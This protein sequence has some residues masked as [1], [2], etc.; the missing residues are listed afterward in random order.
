ME[1]NS[2]AESYDYSQEEISYELPIN[3]PQPLRTTDSSTERTIITISIP[4]VLLAGAIVALTVDGCYVLAIVPITLTACFVVPPIVLCLFG[5]RDVFD[6][7]LGVCYIGLNAIVLAPLILL[8]S[9]YHS[10]GGPLID[11]ESLTNYV[12][13]SALPI[14]PLLYIGYKYG[15]RRRNKPLTKYRQVN[16]GRLRTIAAVLIVLG[17]A[18]RYLYFFVIVNADIY[19]LPLFIRYFVGTIL[20]A[21]DAGNIGI[22]MLLYCWMIQKY[23]TETI[24]TWK[25]SMIIG[26]TAASALMIFLNFYRGSRF[27]MIVFPIW[28]LCLYAYL[29]R[30]IPMWKLAIIVIVGVPFMTAYKIAR[31]E[32]YENLGQIFFNPSYRRAAGERWNKDLRS[33]LTGDFARYHTWLVYKQE[34]EPEGNIDFQ[35][36]ATYLGALLQPIPKFIYHNKDPG[37]A[38]LSIDAVYGQGTYNKW[39]SQGRTIAA[40]VG[41]LW[42]EGYVNFGNLG[43]WLSSL[44]YGYILGRLKA[45][46]IKRPILDIGHFMY[47]IAFGMSAGFILGD[48]RLLTWSAARLLIVAVPVLWWASD[49]VILIEK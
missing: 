21:A 32:N 33:T 19:S 46:F 45:Y 27:H 16:I 28:G 39:Q 8:N 22:L 3:F 26:L 11:I 37:M 13:W 25:L 42:A 17:L 7:W 14:V 49:R 40:P 1:M 41:G 6:I 10:A 5:Y 35:Y 47:A 34:L 18:A 31:F 48:M 23:T 24:L 9:Y 4:F 20:V 38:K 2:M 29:I 44:F 15:L 30:P 36:G 43:V 12:A